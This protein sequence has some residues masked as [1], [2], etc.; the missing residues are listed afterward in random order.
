MEVVDAD[1]SSRDDGFIAREA[2]GGAPGLNGEFEN[3]TRA[4][5]RR[6]DNGG[7]GT[8]EV[9][10]NKVVIPAQAMNHRCH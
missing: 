5:W 1:P 2:A 4:S 3:A 8:T 6:R 10:V 7:E 9:N